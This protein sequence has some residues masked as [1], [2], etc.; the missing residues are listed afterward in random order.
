MK[1]GLEHLPPTKRRELELVV[2]IL[3]AEFQDATVLGTQAH[4]R[5]GRILKIILYGSRRAARA[6]TIRSAAMCRTSTSWSWS[7]TSG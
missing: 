4:K 2:E 5:L 3:F 7:T 6:W 1:T